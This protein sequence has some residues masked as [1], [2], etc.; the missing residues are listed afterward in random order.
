M[1]ALPA[2]TR[3]WLACG[4]T[5]L[6]RLVD[7]RATYGYRRI[8]ALLNRERLQAGLARLN[9]KRIYRLCSQ[10]GYDSMGPHSVNGVQMISGVCAVL[11]A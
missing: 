5:D 8:G 6:R 3:I 1:I 11:R 2:G 4:V 9:R 10:N 7:E